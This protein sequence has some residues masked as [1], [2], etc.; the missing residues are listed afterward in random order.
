MEEKER[1]EKGEN[2]QKVCQ[3]VKKKVVYAEKCREP[4]RPFSPG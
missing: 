3:R 4:H 1:E 2:R